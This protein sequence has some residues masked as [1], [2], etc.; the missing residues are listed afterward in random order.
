[1]TEDYIR[2]TILLRLGEVA[3]ETAEANLD[4]GTDVTVALGLDD[5]DFW[6]FVTAVGDEL[7]LQIPESDHARFRT[8]EGGVAYLTQHAA[9]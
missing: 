7:G 8:I 4:P 1:M 2:D 3:P 9:A 6:A 5:T